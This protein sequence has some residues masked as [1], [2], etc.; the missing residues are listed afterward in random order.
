MN[1][2][3][4]EVYM[5]VKFRIQQLMQ[6]GES[7]IKFKLAQLRSGIGK[8]PG[9]ISALWDITMEG[10][11]ESLMSTSPNGAPSFGEWAVHSAMTLF[12]LHQ[13]GNDLKQKCMNREGEGFGKTVRKLVENADDFER[14]KRRFDIVVTSNSIEEISHHLRGIIQLL[15]T[16][17]LPLNYPDLAQ[18]LFYF[19]TIKTRDNTR[20]KWGRDFY[21][22]Q[23]QEEN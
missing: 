4:N 20:L 13:Q 19:Q 18:D 3:T 15:K 8:H 1:G 14:I 6:L 17:D 5:F 11:P 2:Q 21:R 9:N 10:L 23:K 7:T 16:K 22:I 12:A